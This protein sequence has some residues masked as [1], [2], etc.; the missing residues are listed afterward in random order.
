MNHM[1]KKRKFK[2]PEIQS[3][4]VVFDDISRAKATL[5]LLVLNG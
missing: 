3:P 1:T 2:F 5:K 4:S